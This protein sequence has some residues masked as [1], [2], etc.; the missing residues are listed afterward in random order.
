MPY[1]KRYPAKKK[2]GKK[3]A[4]AHVPKQPS[5]MSYKQLLRK[6]PEGFTDLNRL[7]VLH[8]VFR[9]NWFQTFTGTGAAAYVSQYTVPMDQYDPSGP[10]GIGQ[11]YLFDQLMALY[12]YGH[13]KRI[14]LTFD[15]SDNSTTTATAYYVFAVADANPANTATAAVQNVDDLLQQRD[16]RLRPAYSLVQSGTGS[17]AGG[18]RKLKLEFDMAKLLGY[19]KESW[20]ATEVGGAQSFQLTASPSTPLGTIWYGIVSQSSAAIPATVTAT[21][22]VRCKALVKLYKPVDMGPS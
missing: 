15:F 4:P 7:K 5:K 1:K 21:C 2:V 6:T 20:N 3:K 22:T 11:P 12:T 16:R 19:S 17:T 10:V 9:S 18:R 13:A 14:R 8:T